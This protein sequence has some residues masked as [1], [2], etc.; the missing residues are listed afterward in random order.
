MS[1]FKKIEKKDKSLLI[2]PIYD[3]DRLDKRTETIGLKIKINNQDINLDRWQTK[4]IIEY[5]VSI[6]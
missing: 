5:M 3:N 4:A 2:R 1:S 6:L